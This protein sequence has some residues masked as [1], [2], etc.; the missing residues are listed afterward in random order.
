MRIR[1]EAAFTL[2]ELLVVIAIIGVLVALLIPAVQVA[3]ESARRM[4][5]SNNLKQI[6][7]AMHNYHSTYKRLTAQGGGTIRPGSIHGQ[8]DVRTNMRTQSAL[9]GIL[10]FMEQQTLWESL[11]N[12]SVETVSG[13]PVED[14]LFGLIDHWPPM[15]PVPWLNTEY[16]PWMTEVPTFRCPSDPGVGLPA[17][18]RTNFAVCQGDSTTWYMNF[19]P[20][21]GGWDNDAMDWKRS[22]YT[23][24]RNFKTGRGV[25]VF[26]FPETR[27]RDIHDG[28]SNTILMGEIVTGLGD[29]DRRGHPAFD[30]PGAYEAANV[31]QGYLSPTRP[32]FWSDG[33]DGGTAPPGV[34]GIDGG[35][36]WRNSWARG[37]SWASAC[38][39]DTMFSTQLPPNRESCADFYNKW[40]PGQMGASSHHPSGA[41]VLMADGS[42][43]FIS[44]SIDAGNSASNSPGYGSESQAILPEPLEPGAKSP[45]GLWGSLGTR[46]SK[47]VIGDVF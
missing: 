30:V 25:F 43:R 31:C 12:S 19:G 33:M 13:A 22:E 24:V 28:L 16:V 34:Y 10:P 6:G 4:S 15:G 3:R 8:F 29:R 18:G 26:R 9:V 35:A 41:H 17:M 45:Y 7:L 27:F 14:F 32:L 11:S 38:G 40:Y 2:V 36:S 23:R 46:A 5:C 39:L 20:F 21:V 42:V 37:F 44:D 1:R 47:E